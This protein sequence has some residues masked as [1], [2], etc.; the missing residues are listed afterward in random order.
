M[1]I[2]D[3][4]NGPRPHNVDRD[5]KISPYVSNAFG[6]CSSFPGRDQ[7]TVFERESGEVAAETHRNAE[8]LSLK[9]AARAS[10]Q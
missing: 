1:S 3:Q 8:A 5:R 6:R 2:H 10:T 9:C 7:I 4:L